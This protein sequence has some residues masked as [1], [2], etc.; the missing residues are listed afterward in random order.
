M[1]RINYPKEMNAKTQDNLLLKLLSEKDLQAFKR[2]I[3]ELG[4]DNDY[5]HFS[6]KMD[7]EPIPK[8]SLI[9]GGGL[10]KPEQ[11]LMRCEEI[12]SRHLS[13]PRP[14]QVTILDIMND[15]RGGQP[16]FSEVGSLQPGREV[17]NQ[18][19]LRC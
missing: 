14:G 18:A 19:Q 15:R 13:L 4:E 1:Q 8:K 9:V 11:A 12:G 6:D 2:N 3:E 5:F 17:Q 7:E 10:H 16:A